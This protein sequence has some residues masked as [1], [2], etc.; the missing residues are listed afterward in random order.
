MD[1]YTKLFTIVSVILALSV[2]SERLVEIIKGWNTFLN[3]KSIDPTKENKRK[4]CIHILSL[5]SGCLTVFLAWNFLPTEL[6]AGLTILQQLM[7]GFALGLLAS[8]GS[9]FWNSI[10]TYMLG[11]KEL[12]RLEV[13]LMST[14]AAFYR[15]TPIVSLQTGDWV[16]KEVE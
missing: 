13:S 14:A 11:L 7:A 5:L 9:S 16:D 2:A 12:K 1:L 10:L 6:T 3:T 4:T 15:D 8:G